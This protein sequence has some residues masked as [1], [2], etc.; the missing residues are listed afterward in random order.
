MTDAPRRSLGVTRVLIIGSGAPSAAHIPALV[1]TLRANFATEVRVSLT[2]SAQTLVSS[3]AVAVA[4][5]HP[6]IGEDWSADGTIAHRRWSDWSEMVVV[7]PATLDFLA[8]CAHGLGSDVPA[9]IVLSSAAPVLF[10][11]SLAP[12]AVTGGPYRRARDLL[13]SDGH[14]VVD[15]VVG[16]GMSDM[17]MS[18]GACISAPQLIR[19]IYRVKNA[20]AEAPTETPGR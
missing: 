10:A 3:R 1:S 15:P 20:E 19:A 8:R 14:V 9:A 7:W 18:D 17:T 12:H 2:R 11:P 5:G 13:R 16:L 6:V 4:C